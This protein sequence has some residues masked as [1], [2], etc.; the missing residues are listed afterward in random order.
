M[1]KLCKDCK[2]WLPLNDFYTSPCTHDRRAVYCKECHK[3]RT[4]QSVQRQRDSRRVAGL[5]QNAFRPPKEHND[6]Y[7]DRHLQRR[8]QEAA[9]EESLMRGAQGQQPDAGEMSFAELKYDSLNPRP[10][11]RDQINFLLR[12]QQR[13]FSWK[14]F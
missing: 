3:K 13:T 6:R 9:L 7:L 10:V 1:M 14:T 8:E 2:G 12:K 4:A 5:P 11:F